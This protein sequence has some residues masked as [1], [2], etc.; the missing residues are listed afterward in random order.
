MKVLVARSVF[1]GKDLYCGV[2]DIEGATISK[3]EASE[4]EDDYCS[5]LTL[6]LVNGST[7]K[8]IIK[9]EK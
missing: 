8:I 6:N 7:M 1:G 2:P 9:Q 3:V 4:N 5:E